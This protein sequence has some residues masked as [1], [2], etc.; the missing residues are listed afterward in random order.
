MGTLIYE[1]V[2]LERGGSWFEPVLILIGK[3]SFPLP[4]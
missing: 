3:A 4:F 1:I 2:N